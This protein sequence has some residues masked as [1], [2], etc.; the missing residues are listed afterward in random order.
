MP[1]VILKQLQIVTEHSKTKM[2]TMTVNTNVLKAQ[3]DQLIKK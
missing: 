3:G 1:T 2:L